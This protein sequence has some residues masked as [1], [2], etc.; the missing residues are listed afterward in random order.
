[1][2][3]IT[4]AGHSPSPA[5]VSQA[6][7]PLLPLDYDRA[8]DRAERPDHA[9]RFDLGPD[10]DEG[11]DDARTTPGGS[12][13]AAYPSDAGRL[14]RLVDDEHGFV[15]R[16]IRRLGVRESDVDDGVQKV[17]LVAA[18]RLATFPPGRERAFLFATCMR[19]AAN[20]R[21]GESRR[22]SAGAEALEGLR[23]HG[24]SPEQHA[25]DRHLLDRLLEPLP[26][27]LRSVLV[28]FELEG[29]TGDEI[30]ELLD[31]PVGT[32]A[33]RLR[34]GRELAT[35]AAKRLR[36]SEGGER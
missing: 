1:M 27:E 34:R 4:L 2:I 15:W 33:S 36:A 18:Q 20:E 17:F 32:V 13:V 6:S 3:A 16:S 35:A 5:I 11:E 21:R 10:G 23:S 31:L 19:V 9:E 22:R 25:S 28:L 7:I 14:R 30:G 8:H 24:P 26:L 12:Q 29:M